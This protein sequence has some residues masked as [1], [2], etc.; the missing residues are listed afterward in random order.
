MEVEYVKDYLLSFQK[1]VFP[2]MIERELKVKP[3]E[4]KA[5]TIIGPRRAGKTFYF[6]NIISNMERSKVL[7]LDFEEPFLKGLSS[8]DV[9]RI[10]LEMFPEVVERLP[11][12]VFLDEI[13]NV[14]LWESLVRSLLNRGFHVFITGS[15]SR[16]LSREVATQLR[17]RIITYLLLPFSFREYL[18]AKNVHVEPNLLENRGVIKRELKNYLEEGGFP[19][20][21]LREEKEKI[22]KEYIDLAFFKD[23]VERHS[24]KSITLARYVF[25]DLIQNFSQEI[26]VRAIERRLKSQGL[27]FNIMTLYRYVENLEDTLFIY[28]LRKFS[29]KA[30]ERELWPR[31]VY[32]ADTGLAKYTMFS[33]DYG[34]LMENI[35]F[36]H[37]LRETN[38]NPLLTFYYWKDYNQNEVDFIIKDGLKVKELVQVTYASNK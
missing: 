27:S 16:L 36:L 14:S 8:F 32:L 31:K 29:M 12:F 4:R 37:L 28:F 6:F 11:E 20:I 34:K 2:S 18:K 13:Q 33:Q 10:V 25:N 35:V 23:F 5:V 26:S 24:V 9:L 19:E 22:L 1:T 30:H 21:V 17:G 38:Q 3:V 7:Y 15:S